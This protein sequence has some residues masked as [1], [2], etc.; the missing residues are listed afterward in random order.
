MLILTAARVG[1]GCKPSRLIA[2]LERSEGTAAGERAGDIGEAVP[3]ESP[4][5]EGMGGGPA[6]KG[7]GLL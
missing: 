2:A 5:R 3:S 1:L 6:A 7:E 4:G